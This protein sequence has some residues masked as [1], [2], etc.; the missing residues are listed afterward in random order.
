VNLHK[1]W[2]IARREYM[3]NFRR[4]AFLFT[5]FG[6]PAI[7]IGVTL[8]VT[9]FVAEQVADISKYKRVGVIDQAGIF[10][11]GEQIK[12]PFELMTDQ[13]TAETEVRAK[14]L[15]GYFVLP[16]DFLSKGRID[17]YSRPELGLAEGIQD[18]L[19]SEIKGVLAS[20]ISDP[21]LAKRLQTPL[22]DVAIYRA[23]TNERLQ[24]FVLLASFLVP[25][26][27][28]FLIFIASSTTSQFLMS[29]LVEEKENRMLE[30]FVTSA[31]TS[32]IL[33]GKLLGLGALGMT[34]LIVWAIIAVVFFTAQR[35]INLAQ[36]LSSLEITPGYLLLLLALFVLGYLVNGA[37]MF[38]IGALA[39]A[40]QESRQ[41]GGFLSLFSVMPF[42]FL[43]FT[44]T[45]PNGTLSRFL[46][47]FPLTAPVGMIMRMSWADVPPLEIALCLGL[48]ILTTL[49][50]IWSASK[51]FRLGMLNYGKRL[52]VKDIVR[53][54]REAS[55]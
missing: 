26:F 42:M 30:M 12:A 5:V 41:I 13:E 21:V 35:D 32:E 1:I 51:L 7:T 39:N 52:G 36:L 49:V 15:D 6:I 50:L 55:A 9:V 34:Q 24:E 8:L 47:L 28:G 14:T 25:F 43:G 4:R 31:R 53:S 2:L 10:T 46:S 54:L 3:I 18:R 20:S 37:L 38:S 19:E 48:L 33:W 17:M 22:D 40:E 29:G 11:S 45:D 23:G 27:A 44:I 16:K